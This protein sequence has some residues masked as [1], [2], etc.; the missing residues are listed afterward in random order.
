MLTLA[1]VAGARRWARIG[2]RRDDVLLR[3]LLAALCLLCLVVL[4]S[5]LKRLGLYEEAFGA[6]RLRLLADANIR[7]LGAVLGLVLVT[8]ALGRSGWLPRAL[9]LLSAVGAVAFAVSNPDGRI[10]SRNVDRYLDG[11]RID[12][13]YLRELSADAAEPLTRLRYPECIADRLL[14]RLARP[15]GILGANL[16]RQRARNALEGLPPSDVATCPYF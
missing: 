10:A 14:E 6:T 16:A 9:V 11:G 2:G 1:V 4:A 15:D 3:A 12:G 5:A 13:S 8:L 7:W